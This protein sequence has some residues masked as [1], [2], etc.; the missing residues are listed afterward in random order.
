[1]VV[2]NTRFVY[3]FAI[4]S[5]LFV[6]VIFGKSMWLFNKSQVVKIGFCV[7][8]CALCLGFTIYID[9][10]SFCGPCVDA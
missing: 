7:L 8:C 5:R 3:C 9:V 6:V 10:F 1:M 2:G 4:L